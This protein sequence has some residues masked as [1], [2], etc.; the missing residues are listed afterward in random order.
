MPT[1]TTTLI[2]AAVIGYFLGS[3]P[4]GYLLV[5]FFLK[6]D[7]RGTGSGN[8][9]ATNVARTS[10]KLGVLTLLLDAFKGFAAVWIA[11]Q[12]GDA[13][14]TSAVS[15]LPMS[16]AALGAVVGHSFPIW[17][18]FR[19]GKSV[20]TALGSFVLIAPLAVLALVALFVSIVVLT[21]YVSLGST[22]GALLFP[23][24]AWRLDHR[25]WP[26]LALLAAA[27]LL[28]FIRHHANI[29][30]LLGGNE[31]RFGFGVKG[32]TR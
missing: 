19:G 25:G 18:R 31:S 22:L 8:I 23:I 30:R 21:R 9:G 28:V 32:Q 26:E 6:H 3:I 7:V 14:P 16:V 13:D 2:A 17:L 4:F 5:R 11:S 1:A 10:P 15:L 27:S 29:R 24:L 12:L 20:A